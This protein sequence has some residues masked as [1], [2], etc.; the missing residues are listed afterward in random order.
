MNRFRTHYQKLILILLACW[1]SIPSAM[2][3]GQDGKAGTQNIL[4][5]MG[6]GARVFGL[7]RAFVALA[8]DPSAVFW[9]PAGLEYVPRISFSLFHTPLVVKGASYD[10]IGFVYPTVQLGTVGIGY[11]RVGL[12]LGR[13]IFLTPKKRCGV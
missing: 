10:F 5:E 1:L 11:S 3:K 4:H 13:F 7:G 8:D 2:L 12:I 9:N 6:A